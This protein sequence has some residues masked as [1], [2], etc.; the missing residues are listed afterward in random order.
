LLRGSLHAHIDHFDAP[1]PHRLYG[2]G[3]TTLSTPPIVEARHEHY[4]ACFGDLIGRGE[5]DCAVSKGFQVT[6]LRLG[7]HPDTEVDFYNTHLEAG[8][9]AEDHAVRESQL[10]A[11]IAALGSY[12]FA[13][14]VVLVADTNAS[15]R[16][17]QRLLDAARLRDACREVACEDPERIERVLVRS[18]TRLRLDVRDWRLEGAFFDLEGEPLSDHPAVSA[19]LA[20]SLAP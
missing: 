19:Q 5:T 16:Q 11:L 3:L 2:A 6:R 1:L 7:A 17:L 4:A 13:R 18:N 10:D 12:S 8:E 9:D 20:W 15:Q 14:A